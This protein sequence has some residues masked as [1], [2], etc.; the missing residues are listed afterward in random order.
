MCF[1]ALCF[2]S[3]FFHVGNG[4]VFSRA[5]HRLMSRTRWSSVLVSHA[6]R[7][8]TRFAFYRPRVSCVYQ[9][10]ILRIFFLIIP[11]YFLESGSNIL[12]LSCDSSAMSFL[13]ILLSQINTCKHSKA[14][15][16]FLLSLGWPVDVASHPGWSGNI[17]EAWNRN[18]N[19]DDTVTL[20]Q[21]DSPLQSSQSVSTLTSSEERDI[22]GNSSDTYTSCLDSFDSKASSSG[23]DSPAM[24]STATRVPLEKMADE[25]FYFAD[26][27][28]EVAFIV[29]SLLPSYQRF[30]HMASHAE[31]WEDLG[32][33]P[34]KRTRSG[35]TGSL[36][37]ISSGGGSQFDVRSKFSRKV[38]EGPGYEVNWLK[39]IIFLFL[40]S[41]K[42]GESLLIQPSNV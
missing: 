17:Q 1:P 32:Y 36:E 26:V 33:A 24:N 40:F 9:L 31:S 38:S 30:R 19:D 21:R 8:L 39:Q 37:T 10:S 25:I 2:A 16:E 15:R 7:N 5:L 4:H 6:L 12:L 20:R 28:C 29:P 42:G 18:R 41:Q 13:F 34:R 22:S 35:S 14:F 27:S 11:F 3:G 23:K